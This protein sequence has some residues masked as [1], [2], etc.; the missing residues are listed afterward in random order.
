[1]EGEGG[2]I[3]TDPTAPS[4]YVQPVVI[5]I[6]NKQTHFIIQV[7]EPDITYTGSGFARGQFN[8]VSYFICKNSIK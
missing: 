2:I 3:L 7:S 1:M 8:T 4:I 5:R 6:L